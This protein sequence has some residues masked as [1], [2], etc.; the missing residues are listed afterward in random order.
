MLCRMMDMSH[1][2]CN[3][4]ISFGLRVVFTQS[5]WVAPSQS[6]NPWCT[7]SAF[8]VLS[9]PKMHQDLGALW[10]RFWCSFSAFSVL[11]WHWIM[12]GGC[13]RG[14]PRHHNE[15]PL[16][17]TENALKVHRKCTQSAPWSRCILGAKNTEKALNVHCEVLGLGGTH[18][19][20]A[21]KFAQ[22]SP[23]RQ[24]FLPNWKKG[25][26]TDLSS[27]KAWQSNNRRFGEFTPRS[28]F[29]SWIAHDCMTRLTTIILG[30]LC[31]GCCSFL[32]N[33]SFNA[34]RSP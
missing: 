25:C 30:P 27:N 19:K 34:Q 24:N 2:F 16:K 5:F 32:Q 11:S 28:V 22:T 17:S 26:G 21:S 10:V 3:L 29:D 15:T 13:F 8:S 6:K 31:Y 7:F 14:F 4:Q 12:L 20:W 18:S 1:N 23:R 33:V 9:A